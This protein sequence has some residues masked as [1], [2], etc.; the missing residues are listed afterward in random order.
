MNHYADSSFLVSC[1][2]IDATTP[3]ANSFLSRTAAP[4][5]WTTLHALKVRNAFELGVFRGLLTTADA[6]AAWA[7]LEN[8]LRTARLPRT[9]VKW[10][11]ALRLC[12]PA[13]RAPFG[14]DWDA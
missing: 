9:T 6:K 10:P 12:R 4:L 7:S 11:A 13:E 3:Q 2:L 14:D 1:Y 8:D 5:A